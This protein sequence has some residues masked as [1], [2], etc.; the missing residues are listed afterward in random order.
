MFSW[1]SQVCSF[2]TGPSCHRRVEVDEFPP[3]GPLLLPA[4]A[5]QWTSFIERGADGSVCAEVK[6]KKW[7]KEKNDPLQ[8]TCSHTSQARFKPH[9]YKANSRRLGQQQ[10]AL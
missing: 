2:S 4:A 6:E 3:K 7:L 1:W 9:S 8:L 10:A 5:T